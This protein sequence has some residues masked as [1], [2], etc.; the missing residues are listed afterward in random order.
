[1]ETRQAAFR[2]GMFVISGIVALLALIFFLSGATLHP[3]QKYETYF[4][5]SVEGLDI[6]TAVKFRG[7][8]IGHVTDVGLVIAEYPPNSVAQ[9]ESKAYRQIVVRFTVDPKKIGTHADVADGIAHGLRAQI[10]PQGITG[11]SYLD[12]SFVSPAAYPVTPVPWTPDS[13]VVPSIPSTL[14]Q[15][16]D[17]LE[18]VISSLTRVDLPTMVTQ[19][20][21]LMNTL[22][23]EITTGDAHQAIANANQLLGNLNTTVTQTNLPGTSAA[24]R[25]LADGPQT[26]QIIA[27][28]NQTTAQLAKISAQLP[29]LV[30]ASQATINQA[31]ET[32]ADLQA[33]LIPILQDMKSTTANLRAL[34]SELSRNP[35]QV[36]LGA[37][38]PPEGASP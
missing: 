11:L 18:Q 22:T 5:E 37:P 36:L 35:S 12:L 23:N 6:G 3:G 38:P 28:L 15:L 7:V 24:I 17:A 21:T 20:S 8:T 31:N 29:A 30:A 1:M 16:Q 2:V 33:Q 4:Q 10:E 34:S 26:A 14:T 9:A 13:R 25:N 27:Q 19:A 32:T